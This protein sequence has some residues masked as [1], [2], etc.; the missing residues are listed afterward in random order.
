MRITTGEIEDIDL[1]YFHGKSVKE[2]AE[3]QLGD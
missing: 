2:V 3:I 1:V